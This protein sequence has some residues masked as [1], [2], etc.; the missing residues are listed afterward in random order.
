M[1]MKA[2]IRFLIFTLGLFLF[3]SLSQ[4][5]VNLK[6]IYGDDNREDFYEVEDVEIK[7]KALSVVALVQKSYLSKRF[8]YFYSFLRKKYGLKNKLCKT[9]RF[10]D[11]SS[12]AF[13][14]GALVTDQHILTAA[15]CARYCESTAVVFGYK[16]RFEGE[17]IRRIRASHVYFCENVEYESFHTYT[18]MA[19]LKL[20]RPVPSFVAE[21]LDY[22]KNVENLNPGD[23][24]Y[25]I[26]HPKGLPVK[27]TSKASVRSSTDYSFIA[28]LDAY[29]G[30]SGSPVFNEETGLI[31]GVLVSGEKDYVEHPDSK[32]TCRVSHVCQDDE[33][34][35][36]KVDYILKEVSDVID[37]INGTLV[38]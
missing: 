15:H 14:S 20:D 35:G 12:L 6:V 37:H 11:Q 21:K 5:E 8:N 1:F 33:C 29:A 23:P 26:G 27:V 17:K 32:K 31:E 16:M 4:S 30:N 24:I 3:T 7:K 38:N 2:C 34:D 13:C 22:Q 36:E 25:M 10:F 19:L 9:E 18:D 28:N